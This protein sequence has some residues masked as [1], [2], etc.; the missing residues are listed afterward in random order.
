MLTGLFCHD[1]SKYKNIFSLKKVKCEGGL[2]IIIMAVFINAFEFV[3]IYCSHITSKL[4]VNTL[5]L[6]IF[7]RKSRGVH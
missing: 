5:L 4:N 7:I 1:V 6:S 3:F 2:L